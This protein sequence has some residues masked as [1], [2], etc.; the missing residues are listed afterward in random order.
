MSPLLSQSYNTRYI[1]HLM[2]HDQR[3]IERY[4]MLQTRPPLAMEWTLRECKSMSYHRSMNKTAY[5]GELSGWELW[6]VRPH[7]FRVAQ[8]DK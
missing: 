5:E 3:K 4:E 7:I 6:G 2:L 1:L 8:W